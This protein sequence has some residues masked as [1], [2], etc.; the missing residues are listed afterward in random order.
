[1]YVRLC[2]ATLLAAATLSTPAAAA[3]VQDWAQPGYGA[4]NTYY[5]PG[6]SV[7]NVGSVN[8]VGLRWTSALATS[9]QWSCSGPSEPLVS[10]GRVFVT[11]GKGIAAY[12]AATGRLSWRHTWANPEDESTPRL[13]VAGGL[14]LAANHGCQSQSD[15]N[16]AIM[17][18]NLVTG[19]QA[20]RTITTIP[21]ASL[22]VD[23]GTAVVSGA[24]ASDTPQVIGVRASDG[25]RRWS[26][27]DFRSS[28]VS[29]GG[30]VL[31]GSTSGTET[32]AVSATTGGTLWSRPTA[33]NAEAANPAGDRF[34]ATGAGGALVCVSSADGSVQWTAAKGASTQ[35]AADGRRVYRVDTN[36]IE[37]LNARTG[38]HAWAARLGAGTGQPVR[39]G[40][41]LYTA[42]GGG[43][44]L[45]IVNAANGA[46]AS[47]GKQIGTLE[48]GNV[49]VTAG[50]IYLTR[51]NAVFGYA[52]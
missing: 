4:G 21:L 17:A 16:G 22:V 10:G 9:E 14:L 48:R 5:N 24:S 37:A 13:A 42:V 20:W 44:P 26:L 2:A 34:Y 25:A 31:V 11:D 19:R 39:A 49:V 41:L 7:I 6:E 1:M 46:V 32:R 8:S 15:P 23:K 30:R 27:D 38:R 47:S 51:G 33:W 52:R 43:K 18:L 40:G 45:G 3:A 36:G 35:V 12:Q 50:W 28:G 29:A